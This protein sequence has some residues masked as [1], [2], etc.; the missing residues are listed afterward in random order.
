MLQDIAIRALKLAQMA[1]KP[2]ELL[3]LAFTM[4]L[5]KCL[6]A[7][8]TGWNYCLCREGIKAQMTELQFFTMGEVRH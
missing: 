5:F 6:L 8:K 4:G 1:L 2:E 7:D 3:P